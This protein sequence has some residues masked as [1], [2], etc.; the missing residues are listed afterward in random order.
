MI[1]EYFKKE[2]GESLDSP[3]FI[4]Q[5]II[6]QPGPSVASTSDISFV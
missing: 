1:K 3:Q 4:Y 5:D 2:K 6:K